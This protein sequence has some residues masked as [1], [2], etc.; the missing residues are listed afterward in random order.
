MVT[1]IPHPQIF[2]IKSIIN[3]FF[4]PFT[5]LKIT[6]KSLFSLSLSKEA[7]KEI[8]N[9]SKVILNL[10]SLNRALKLIKH[11]SIHSSSFQFQHWF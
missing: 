7:N 10:D 5:L 3:L 1:Y 11:T 9:N 6:Q 4:F 8:L 2:F